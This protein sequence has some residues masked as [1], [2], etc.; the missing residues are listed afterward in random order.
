MTLSEFY[1]RQIPGYYPAMYLDGYTPAQILQAAKRDMYQK[2]KE[3]QQKAEIPEF[4][5]RSVVKV[6]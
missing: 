4:K 6:T 3:A 2:H 1:N 5:F